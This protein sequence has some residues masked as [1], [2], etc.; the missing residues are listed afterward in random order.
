MVTVGISVTRILRFIV[1]LPATLVALAIKLNVPAAV[2][3]PVIAPLVVFR[4]K[5]VGSAPLPIA[6]VIGVVPVALSVW[7]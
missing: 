4:F 3:V 2:G 5:P 7:L 6:Q 1:T